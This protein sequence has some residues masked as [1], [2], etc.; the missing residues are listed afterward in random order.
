MDT[1]G[2]DHVQPVLWCRYPV[3]GLMFAEFG[4]LKGQRLCLGYSV[5]VLFLSKT[6]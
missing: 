6:L 3:E 2:L 1:K 4:I 5:A